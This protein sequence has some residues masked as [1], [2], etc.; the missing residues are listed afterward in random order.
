MKN[1]FKKKKKTF[2]GL[3]FREI[4]DGTPATLWA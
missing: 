2:L 3:S 4:F 1:D